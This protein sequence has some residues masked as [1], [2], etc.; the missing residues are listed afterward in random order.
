MLAGSAQV[1]STYHCRYM[2]GGW[3]ISVAWKGKI[4][5]SLALEA[6]GSHI[7][8]IYAIA[9]QPRLDAVFPLVEW[10]GQSGLKSPQQGPERAN[11]NR[12]EVNRGLSLRFP[13]A[14]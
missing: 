13:P 11:K 5:L 8:A 9:S 3:G 7:S 4:V 6:D 14:Q 10:K 12:L 1:E 2:N